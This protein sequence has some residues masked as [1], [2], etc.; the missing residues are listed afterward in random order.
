[1]RGKIPEDEE[2]IEEMAWL[3]ATVWG[4]SVK[5]LGQEWY[6]SEFR[7]MSL[8]RVRKFAREHRKSIPLWEKM[9][10]D[11]A[12]PT[13]PRVPNFFLSLQGLGIAAGGRMKAIAPH[14]PTVMNHA[15]SMR[16]LRPSYPPRITIS[17]QA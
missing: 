8:D 6:T 10:F 4:A 15:S 7:A 16:Q 11:L 9:G 12:E 2:D 3:G 13:T 17:V 5:D 1:M 14:K